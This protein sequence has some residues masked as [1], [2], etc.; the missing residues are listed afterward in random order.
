MSRYAYLECQGLN[1]TINLV[2]EAVEK[3][4]DNQN[5]LGLPWAS[6]ASV[7]VSGFAV[8]A[9]VSAYY[10]LNKKLCDIEGKTYSRENSVRPVLGTVAIPQNLNEELNDQPHHVA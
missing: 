6:H 7:V 9:I 8:M 3:I 10:L 4:Y 1:E 2:Y 5:V